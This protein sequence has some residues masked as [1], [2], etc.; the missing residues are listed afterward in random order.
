VPKDPGAVSSYKSHTYET[1]PLTHAY[2]YAPA[3]VS[4]PAPKPG[5]FDSKDYDY[6]FLKDYIDPEWVQT[7]LV[8]T[9]NFKTGTFVDSIAT[10]KDKHS[11]AVME[12]WNGQE[13]ILRT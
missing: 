6:K 11:L 1:Q 5:L 3:P 10:N 8:S 2:Q 12:A 13:T 9:P 7:Y 4:G